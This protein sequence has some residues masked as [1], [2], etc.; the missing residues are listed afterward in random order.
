MDTEDSETD[1]EGMKVL[2]IV[3]DQ[4]LR[5]LGIFLDVVFALM[6]FRIVEFL[7][8]F[9]DGQWAHLPHGI[10]SLLA[11]QP[12]NLVRVGFGLVITV[13]YW[14]RKNTLFSLLARSNS[15]L[16][17]LSIAGL[18]FLCLFMYALIADPMYVGGVPTLLLQSVSLV[19]ASLLGLFA[20]RY[21]IRADLTRPELK[22]CAEQIARIDLSNPLTAIFATG[23]AWS[24]LTIWTLSWFVLTP[25]TC[26]LLARRRRQLL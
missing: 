10:L 3:P 13:Y 9:R 18:S 23:L 16:A 20:L 19:I 26:W 11:S 8:P 24:G 14:N 21:A 22:P 5:S 2:D 4:K 12:R 17:T 25:L 1:A 6:F 7:P 15:V